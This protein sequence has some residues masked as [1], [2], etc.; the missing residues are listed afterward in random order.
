MTMR[1]IVKTITL[2]HPFVL[3]GLDEEQPAGNYEVET[4]EELLEDVSFLGY[5]RMSTLIHLHQLKSRPGIT[6]TM[7]IDPQELDAIMAGDRLKEQTEKPMRAE[8]ELL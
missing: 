3:S 1:T 4:D 7:T 6:Q 5:R 8:I 2:S